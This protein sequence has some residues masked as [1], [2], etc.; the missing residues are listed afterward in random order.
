[1]PIVVIHNGNQDYLGYC[2]LQ[3]KKTNPKSRII[4]IGNDS[5]KNCFKFVEHYNFEELKCKQTEELANVYKHLSPNS[6]E[7]ELFCILR[8][9]YLRNLMK[10]L[11]LKKCFHIDSDVMLYCDINKES[12]NFSEYLITIDSSDE[13]TASSP[14]NMFIGDF[15]TLNDFCCYVLNAYKD[16][17]I[18][19]SF[20]N[21]YQQNLKNK[22]MQGISDM[23]LWMF[24]A[25][26]L[27]RQKVFNINNIIDGYKFDHNIRAEDDFE[28]QELSKRRQPLKK[29]KF[30]NGIPYSKFI[31]EGEYKY[32]FIRFKTLHFQGDSK[33]YM[34]DAYRNNRINKFSL[35]KF[36]VKREISRIIDKLWFIQT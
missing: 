10:K 7:F 33:C 11:D 13:K 8:W 9:Y 26:T 20:N 16:E 27:D 24:F 2:L 14:H 19:E 23:N 3:A 1:M 29:I 36:K 12:E 22:Y 17:N 18:V 32:K 25:K 35:F 4:L 5:N 31:G 6:H 30:I 21:I 28:R 15:N 34:R